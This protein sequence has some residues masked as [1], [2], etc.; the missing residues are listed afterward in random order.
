MRSSITVTKLTC[1]RCAK[2]VKRLTTVFKLDAD[3]RNY[4]CGHIAV[5]DLCD[6]CDW[7]FKNFM[8]GMR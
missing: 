2:E 3:S 4:E 6:V 8:D 1:D 7:E 5:G